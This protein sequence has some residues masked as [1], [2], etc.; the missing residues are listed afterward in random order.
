[1]D[2]KGQKS[3]WQRPEGNTGM[4]LMAAMIVGGGYF[5]YTSLPYIITLMQN[6]Y[7]LIGLGAGLAVIIG[8]ASDSKVRNL[9][10]YFYKSFTR[11]LTSAFV[12]IDPIG[13]LNIYVDDIKKKS[14]VMAGE[15]QKLRGKIGQ[16]KKQ[17][18]DNDAELKQK[19]EMASKAKAMGKDKMKI[20]LYTNQASRLKTSNDKLGKLL[21]TMELL[22]KM[23]TKMKKASDFMIEDTADKVKHMT[24]ERDAIRNSHSV[25]KSAKSI[26]AGDNDKKIL[27]DQAMEHV[28]DDIGF[29]LG[30]MESFMTDSQ[31]WLDNV[32]IQ[33]AV[34][35]E[36]GLDM[37][38]DWDNKIATTFLLEEG[39]GFQTVENLNKKSAQPVKLNSTQS[40]NSNSNNYSKYLK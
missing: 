12:T 22:S 10:W 36:K 21:G 2:N 4:L 13:I 28:V 11:K 25:M 20:T 7:T 29:K 9:V 39:T 38:S 34:F 8:L 3:F 30:E 26:I 37:L 23:I 16:L 33:N 40:V 15:I 19:L 14:Q 35:E 18:S 6:V 24:I 1:M 27:F 17:I 5:L 31:D 32:D